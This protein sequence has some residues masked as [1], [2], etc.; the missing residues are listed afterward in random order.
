MGI[1][2]S[3][4][5]FMLAHGKKRWVEIDQGEFFLKLRGESRKDVE[6]ITVK[7]PEVRRVRDG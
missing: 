3:D 2:F 4:D 7:E 6:I 1:C 5:P